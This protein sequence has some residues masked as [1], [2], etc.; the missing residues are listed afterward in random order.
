[1]L[2]LCIIWLN[3]CACYLQVRFEWLPPIS[4]SLTQVTQEGFESCDGNDGNLIKTWS[5]RTTQGTVDI[6]SLP[7]GLNYFISKHD[8]SY[9]VCLNHCNSFLKKSKL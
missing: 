7:V 8:E 9:G 6:G 1:M 2:Q 4:L 3:W 5:P